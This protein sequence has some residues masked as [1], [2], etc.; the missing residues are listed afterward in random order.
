MNMMAGLYN[1]RVRGFRVINF[2]AVILLIA[3]MFGLYWAK[4]RASGD[5]A[6][7]SRIERQI[8]T[9]K[10]DIRGLEAQVAAME[11][12]GTIGR[13]S[14]DYLHLAPE[15]TTQEIT[16]DRLAEV[17]AHPVAAKGA[18]PAVPAP[19]AVAPAPAVPSQVVR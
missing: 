2:A 1:R 3:L 19:A 10:R 5:G 7:I 8:N 15:K 16:P 14:Q 4:T 18:V 6:A 13:L 12:P 9:E 17:A 11:Q